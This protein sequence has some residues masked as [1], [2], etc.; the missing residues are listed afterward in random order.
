MMWTL[1]WSLVGCGGGGGPVEGDY[2]C[3]D[4]ISA[5]V[6]GEEVTVTYEVRGPTDEETYAGATVQLFADGDVTDECRPPCV[7]RVADGAGLVDVTVPRGWFAYRVV[8]EPADAE[9]R[10]MTTIEVGAVHPPDDAGFLNA[11]FDDSMRA[12]FS[13]A[14]GRPDHA[15]AKAVIRGV[16]CTETPVANLRPRVFGP[17]GTEL[18]DLVVAY[19]NRGEGFPGIGRSGTNQDGRTF[20]ANLPEGEVRVELWGHRGDGVDERFA[21]E[22]VPTE[23]GAVTTARLRPTRRDADPV[24][25]SDAGVDAP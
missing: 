4:E 23:A 25:S 19:F 24:C 12:I 15:L 18:T 22:V 20:L 16:D 13:F 8:G 9:D 3:L 1:W 6:A 17:D 14:R 11:L 21:C 10:R 2:S 5:P 7:E